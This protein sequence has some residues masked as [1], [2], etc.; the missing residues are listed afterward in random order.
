MPEATTRAAVEDFLKQKRIAIAGVSRRPQD[1]SRMMLREFLHRG[2]DAIPVNPN[3][4]DMEGIR[5]KARITDIQPPPDAVLLMTSPEK[6]DEL[7]HDCAAAGVKR[8]WMHRGIG[9]SALSANAREFC[10]RTGITVIAGECPFMHFPNAGTVHK[11]HRFF[12]Q[13][14]GRMPK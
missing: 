7:V 8:V 6:A 5:T 4:G 1:F 3:A 11:I 13:I 2:Y 14:S 10:R 9:T 12:R